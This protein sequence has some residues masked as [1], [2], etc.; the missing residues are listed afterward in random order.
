MDELVH[1]AGLA[2]PGLAHHGH[3]LA[4]ARAGLLERLPQGGDFRLAP[5]KAGEAPR[6]RGLEAAAQGAG[7]D[8]LEH[9]HRLCHAL[10]RY[11]SQGLHLHQALDQ[12]Q[13]AAVRRIVPG[14]ASCSMRAAR[15][16][17][18]PTAE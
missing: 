7:P 17:V 6:G 14:V 11:W 13:V 1:Q 5:H 15:C 18:C 3:H 4:V 8:Q 9:L 10:D 12:P 16:V 2:H